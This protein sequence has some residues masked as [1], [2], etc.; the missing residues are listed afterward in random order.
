MRVRDANCGGVL[1]CQ[2]KLI[3]VLARVHPV[4]NPLLRIAVLV[5]ICAWKMLEMPLL[6]EMLSIRVNEIPIIPIVVVEDFLGGLLGAF[7]HEIFPI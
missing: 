2:D 1:R 5:V 4:P 7:A 3:A 6:E